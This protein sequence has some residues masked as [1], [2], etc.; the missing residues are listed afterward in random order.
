MLLSNDPHQKEL[1]DYFH[2]GRK[3]Q[4]DKGEIILRSGDEPRG[5]YHIESGYV[6]IY[7]LSKDGNEHTQM[8]YRP[9]EMFPVLWIFHDA[10]R[11]VYYQATS[12]VTL[13]VVPKEDFKTFIGQNQQLAM[14]LLEQTTDMFRLYAGRIDN[15]LYSDS[16][17]RTAYCLLSLK[18]RMGS[19]QGK[20]WIITVPV[21]HQDIASSVNLTRETV[22]RCMQRLKRHGLIDMNDHRI[23]IK[24]VAGLM[25]IIGFE[26]AVSMWP[27][28]VEH[29]PSPQNALHKRVW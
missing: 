1:F 27:M 20:D 13:W 2:T 17:E 16:Y 7:S 3:L 4:F 6:K 18:D 24:D 9:G 10:I 29:V 25:K 26:E 12:S 28:L 5:V 14:S 21:T 19:Q 15:L 11:N 8:F 22:S 23:V